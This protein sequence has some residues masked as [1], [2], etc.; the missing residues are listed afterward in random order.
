MKRGRNRPVPLRP[1]RRRRPSLLRRIRPFWIVAAFALAALAWGASFLAT[2]PWLRITRIGIDVPAASPVTRDEVREAAAIGPDANLWLIDVRAVRQRIEA[3]PYVD[4]AVVHRGQFPRPFVELS[5]T[6]RRP[7]DC[8]R[9]ADGEVTIDATARVLQRGCVL[10]GGPTIEGAVT[11]L[12]EPGATLGEP[13]IAQLLRDASVLADAGIAVRRLRRDAWDGLEAVDASGVR[14]RFGD[15][16]DL[17]RKAALVAPVRA[18]IGKRRAVAGI[19]LRAPAT[20]IVEF[21]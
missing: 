20:P 17:E 8:V 19:D 13:A 5:V 1:V 11:S 2:S 14:L 6:V 4:R 21:R 18:G 10:P 15:D 16:R 12:P 9:T 3:L 7:A